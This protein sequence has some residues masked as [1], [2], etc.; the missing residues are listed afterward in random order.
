M[1]F[2]YLKAVPE[3]FATGLVQNIILDDEKIGKIID[4]FHFIVIDLIIRSKV[5]G[6]G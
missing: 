2:R 1:L 4:V 3:C 6:F 5:Y